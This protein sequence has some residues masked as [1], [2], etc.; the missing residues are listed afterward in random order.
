M[1]TIFSRK[2]LNPTSVMDSSKATLLGPLA[3]T[4]AIVRRP[5]RKT[6]E[7]LTMTQSGNK[8]KVRCRKKVLQSDLISRAQTYLQSGLQNMSGFIGVRNSRKNLHAMCSI[9]PNPFQGPLLDA[10]GSTCPGAPS[11]HYIGYVWMRHSLNPA[12]R[13]YAVPQ[14]CLP[15]PKPPSDASPRRT[16][17]RWYL[18]IQFGASLS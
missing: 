10:W 2:Q 16:R 12:L 3:T 14:L 4:V 7:S 11:D 1:V 15:L 18:L 13:H 8:E 9:V 6:N 17:T 5:G